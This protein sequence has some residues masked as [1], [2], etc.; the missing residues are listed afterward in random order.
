MG[1]KHEHLETFLAQAGNRTD[2]QKTG[3]VSTPLY[4]STAYRHEGLGE[5]TGYDY[6]RET[7]PTR[8]VLQADL[9]KLENGQQA[10]ALSS[11]MAAIQLVFSKFKS[12]DKIIISDDL[13][14]GSFR[15]FADLHE[16]YGIDFI[17]WDGKDFASLAENLAKP[18]VKT[19]WLETPS[20][21]TM[22]LIDIRKTAALA[23]EYHVEVVVDNTF[24]TPIIQRPL[25]EG[26]DI[27]VHSATKYLGG[28][29]DIL[30]G[31]VVCKGTKDAALYER[32]LN[33]TGAVLDPFS[34]W[35]LLRSLKTLPLRMEKHEKNAQKIVPALKEESLVSKVLYPGRG[36]MISFYVQDEKL[37]DS[38]LRN[39]QVVSFA[40]SLGGVESLVTVPATQTHAD[41][42]EKQREEKNITKNLLRLSVG[43]ENS[44]DLIADIHQSLKKAQVTNEARKSQ[45]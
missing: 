29:N 33:T 25:D 40:E 28:H 35:L 27:V 43:L 38:F 8:D 1:S 7:N 15:Y 20:N 21:P 39:L 23:H 4:F 30:G 45:L 34:C 18:G 36:G 19:I 2:D 10:F 5:S 11:G 14:G 3:A 16:N 13:Y 37:V 17:L 42:T 6:S 31:V 41:L 22:K 12:H 24:Y 26:A 32:N 9:A 44:E